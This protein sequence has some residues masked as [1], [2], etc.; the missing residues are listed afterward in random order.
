[1]KFKNVAVCDL[2][3][4]NTAE[5]AGAIE[6]VQNAAILILP[7][8]SDEETRAAFAKIEMH[9]VATTIYA[10][11]YA[12]IHVYNG[13]TT[14]SDANLPDGESIHVINGKAR[15]LPISSAK[16]VSLVVNGKVVY[17]RNSENLKLLNVNGKAVPMDFQNTVFLPDTAVLHAEK[18]TADG[19]NKYYAADLAVVP[20]VPKTA[21]GKVVSERIIAH[22]SVTESG[23]DLEAE[24]ILYAENDGRILV[25]QDMGELYLTP[26]LLQAVPGKLVITDIGTVRI[27][28]KVSAEQLR[29]KVL[30]IEDVGTVRATKATFDVV[31][32]LARDVGS[33]RR[34]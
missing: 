27:D 4:Y 9:N 34:R 3:G 33:I 7:K 13:N 14:L 2:R 30:I 1:M 28:K 24:D 31:Q 20:S 23:I 5:A 19:E 25:K 12:Q 18:F 21:H 10:D 17:D 11:E 29:E 8:E 22:P 6:S 16:Q 26:T 32:L 15:I